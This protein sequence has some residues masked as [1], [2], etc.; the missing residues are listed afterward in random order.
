MTWKWVWR[1]FES[2][3]R[4]R[5]HGAR[6][7]KDCHMAQSVRCS[8]T[9]HEAC[10]IPGRTSV[11]PRSPDVDAGALQGCPW[12]CKFKASLEYVRQG[13]SEHLWGCAESHTLKCG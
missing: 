4:L 7:R 3:L 11:N 8:P 2:I 5:E 10:L 12:P 9:M 13:A 1:E 6:R